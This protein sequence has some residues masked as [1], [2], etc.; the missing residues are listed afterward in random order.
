[1]YNLVAQVFSLLLL[2]LLC[3]V[4][5]IIMVVE[6]VVGGVVCVKEKQ[7]SVVFDRSGK[8]RDLVRNSPAKYI[9]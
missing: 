5:V 7:K 2:M 9:L 1:M 4:C 3:C 8:Q 6:G